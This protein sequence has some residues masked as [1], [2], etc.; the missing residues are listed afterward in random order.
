MGIQTQGPSITDTFYNNV[1]LFDSL[2][3][4]LRVDEKLVL[5]G[6]YIFFDLEGVFENNSFSQE[7]WKVFR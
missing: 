6:F 5:I 3:E 2:S 4:T 7:K 1:L